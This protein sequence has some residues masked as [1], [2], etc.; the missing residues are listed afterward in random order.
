MT[1][2]T[3]VEAAERLRRHGEPYLVATVV[4]VNGA[5]YRL[6]GARMLLTRF[7]WVAGS[8]S[9]GCLEGDISEKGWLRTKD[10]NP[11]LVTYDATSSVDSDDDI[12]SAFGLGCDGTVEVLLER[13]GTAGRID[14]LEF[15]SRCLRAH[16]RGAVSTVFHSTDPA[17]RVGQRLAITAGGELEEEADK[18]DG[19]LRAA[20]DADM[21]GVIELGRAAN[22]TYETSGGKVEVLI[23]AVLPPPRL[24]LC[25]TGH[26]AVPVATL[27]RSM[28]WDVIVCA[29]EAK[30]STRERFS[31]ANEVLVCAPLD[32]IARISESDRAVAVVMNHNSDRDRESL[33][34]LLGTKLRYVG[35]IGPRSRTQRL[36]RELGL[37]DEDPRVVGPAGVQIGAESPQELAL[38]IISEIQAVLSG[39][40]MA[41]IRQRIA[42]TL[43][44]RA[45]AGS[46]SFASIAVASGVK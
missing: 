46:G 38:A 21:R 11:V 9:G 43:S 4:N 31:M 10:G 22:R 30:Y 35:V 26:D 20:I 28:G 8:V 6:P 13:A 36:L 7:R 33:Q 45:S 25:G 1:E 40:P 19:P 16:K 32:V 41:D 18:I 42:P 15:V 29:S 14:A 3:I 37:D 23:E 39:T 17:I 27:A 24:F 5:A 34:M 44:E 2:R 12:R